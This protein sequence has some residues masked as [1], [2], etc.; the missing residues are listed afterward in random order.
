[1]LNTILNKKSFNLIIA[2]IV[3]IFTAGYLRVHFVTY[4]PDP[5][6]GFYA[7]IAQEI[8]AALSN[9]QN[10]PSQMTLHMYPLIT[11]WVFSLDIN[12]YIALRWIDLLAAA[13]A[14]FLFYKIIG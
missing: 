3:A 7:Y 12:H 8:N 14:S 13:L 1:M 6:G 2:I 4:F 10:I 9:G 11:S 5:D